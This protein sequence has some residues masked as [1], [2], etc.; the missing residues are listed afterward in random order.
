MIFMKQAH[1][2]DETLKQYLWDLGSV[3]QPSSSGLDSTFI[4]KTAVDVLK[5]QVLAVTAASCPFPKRKL[6][7]AKA[8]C[9]KHGI[10]HKEIGFVYGTLDLGS[11]HTGSMNETVEREVAE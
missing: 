4:R 8:F 6:D 7:E 3:A 9:R 11:Y 2:K 1:G 10:R 5:D